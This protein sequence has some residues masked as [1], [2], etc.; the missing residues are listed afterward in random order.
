MDPADLA[1]RFRYHPADTEAKRGAHEEVRAVCHDTAKS[2]NALV[3]EGR[4]KSLAVTKL[5]EAM[6]WANA[7]LARSPSGVPS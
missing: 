4:E 1:T 6:M 3:P 7:G 5:E 2:I